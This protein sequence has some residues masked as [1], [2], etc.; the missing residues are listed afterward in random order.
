MDL[1][2]QI[3]MMLVSLKHVHDAILRILVVVACPYAQPKVLSNLFYYITLHGH[4]SIPSLID[5]D[6]ILAELYALF[7]FIDFLALLAFLFRSILLLFNNGFFLDSSY[8]IILPIILIVGTSRNQWC[9]Q[10]EDPLFQF[11][12]SRVMDGTPGYDDTRGT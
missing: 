6:Q 10:I 2:E 3:K 9:L 4:P 11:E 12:D 5:L 1:F 7:A 8:A